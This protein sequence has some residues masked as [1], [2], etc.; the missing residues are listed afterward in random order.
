[1]GPPS[2]WMLT[3][4]RVILPCAAALFLPFS[5]HSQSTSQN[6]TPV[7]VAQSSSNQIAQTIPD[8][9]QASTQLTASEAPLAPTSASSSSAV[10]S[11]VASAVA[12]TP[13]LPPVTAPSANEPDKYNVS[14]IGHRMLETG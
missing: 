11:T 5:S 7:P 10:P 1:M 2:R 14:L 4:S 12:S 9:P 6:A 3:I 13:S 8:D